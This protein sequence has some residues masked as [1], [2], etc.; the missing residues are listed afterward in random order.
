MAMAQQ[1]TPTP[2]ER[3]EAAQQD[4]ADQPQPDQEQR[5]EDAQQQE[6]RE[7][8][9]Q[10]QQD[11]QR[12]Q[13]RQG[14]QQQPDEGRAGAEAD[15]GWQ[16][17]TSQQEG[18]QGL[19][20]QSLSEGSLAAQ[21]G[22]QQG[23]RIVAIDG[24][25]FNSPEEVQVFFRRIEGTTRVPVTIIRDDQRET[26]ILDLSGQQGRTAEARA[27][28]GVLL[29]GSTD[30]GI[31]VESVFRGSP[32]EEAGLQAGDLIRSVNGET[33]QDVWQ[34]V[35]AVRTMQPGEPVQLQVFRNGRTMTVSP[36]LA[37]GRQAFTEGVVYREQPGQFAG[38]P[39]QQQPRI[40]M[41]PQFQPGDLQQLRQE[42]QSLRQE[43]ANVRRQLNQ[44]QQRGTS[45]SE[46]TS[47]GESSEA[48][49]PTEPS[50][51]TPP[52]D[53]SPPAGAP[54]QPRPGDTPEQPRP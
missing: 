25:E 46:A 13:D 15:L 41:R 44:M 27:S 8:D 20:V 45:G 30:E 34:F 51:A 54:G 48:A 38:P 28:L 17:Q 50:D 40:A 49:R 2:P 19:T 33:Y 39:R 11:Q 26:I 12:E 21:A 16:L 6:Q 35:N 22:L 18:Q 9:Q 3:P 36:E 7:Q 37:P 1:E 52:D 5:P 24:R 23:D 31:W 47:E 10:R 32:A 14:Q 4:Q 42:V 43:L 29:A 53:A